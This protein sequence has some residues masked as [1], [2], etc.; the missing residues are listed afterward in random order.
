MVPPSQRADLIVVQDVPPEVQAELDATWS[1]FLA[2]FGSRR[3]CFGD[4]S[5]M[6]VRQVD[7]GDARYVI[8][9]RRIEV[10]IPTTP[11]RFRESVVHEL[12]HH[13]EHTCSD[14]AE[15]KAVLHSLLGGPQRSWSG[16]GV[17]EEIPSELWAEAAVQLV[18]GERVR[19]ARDMPVDATVIE[20]V[21][22]WASGDALAPTR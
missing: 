8:D 17:W 20:V 3:N 13:V 22:A 1:R 2:R 9:E 10:Q 7:G 5:V 11:K 19:H 15:L 14:F 16:G 12:A 21:K 6:L 18:N 4:V